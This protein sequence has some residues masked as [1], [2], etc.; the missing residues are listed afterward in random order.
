MK[1]RID[2]AEFTCSRASCRSIQHPIDRHHVRHQ[3]LFVTQFAK[4]SKHRA[5]SK[6]KRFRRRYEKFEPEDIRLL[7]RDC[8]SE[9]HEEYLYLTMDAEQQF[10]K[11]AMDF[12]WAQ[13][14]ILMDRFEAFFHK[15]IA[16]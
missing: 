5:H 14:R 2:P 4:H 10:D 8:H 16:E 1:I 13:A 7:C 12:T 9:I 11:Y 3:K 6:F 15:W